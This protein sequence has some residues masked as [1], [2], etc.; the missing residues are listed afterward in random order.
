MIN[1]Q[2]FIVI[3]IEIITLFLGFWLGVTFFK[4]LNISYNF[5]S[6]KTGIISFKNSTSGNK[7][8]KNEIDFFNLVQRLNL[9]ELELRVI[10]RLLETDSMTIK[11]FN[12]IIKVSN[13]SKENQRQRRHLF[14]KELNLKLSLI[15]ENKE[16]IYRNDNEID[17]RSKMYSLNPKIDKEFLKKINAS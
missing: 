1:A 3:F 10:Q 9:Y 7:I 4:K 13:L 11:E 5:Q 17:K 2:Y 15:L 6:G 16:T 12:E 8:S 14:I